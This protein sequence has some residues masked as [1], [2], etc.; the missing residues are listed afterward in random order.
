MQ[1]PRLRYIYSRLMQLPPDLLHPLDPSGVER[2]DP[3][4]HRDLAPLLA[5]DFLARNLESQFRWSV[6]R[7]KERALKLRYQEKSVGLA[8]ED[9][10]R[11]GM[12]LRRLNAQLQ[13]L[14]PQA[15]TSQAP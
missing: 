4:L 14:L 1:D 10:L 2:Q 11:A 5:E 8:E 15:E 13:Q 9:R 3:E 7:L 6:R 12:E